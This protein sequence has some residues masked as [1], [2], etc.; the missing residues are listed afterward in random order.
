MGV[1]NVKDP[2]RLLLMDFYRHINILLPKFF[3]MEN[4]EGLIDKKNAHQLNKAIK[5]LDSRYIVLEPFIV[6]A[7]DYGAPTKRKRVIVI[8][9]DPKHLP[10]LKKSDFIKKIEKQ[11]TVKDAIDDIR[12]PIKQADSVGD[13]G[14]AS[15]R[16]NKSLSSYAME[17]RKPPPSNL[18]FPEVIKYLKQGKLSGH[19]DTLHSD[20]VR[21]RY[22]TGVPPV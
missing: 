19:L 21:I 12:E 2:R 4:V 9:Y 8:G 6:D 20:A 11:T 15:Y 7:S 18:G 3:V 17:M 14:W 13:Y 16:K 22:E 10:H 5:S 1:G